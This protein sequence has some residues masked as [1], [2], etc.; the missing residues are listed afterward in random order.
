MG[1]ELLAKDLSL[2][3][4][5]LFP[6]LANAALSVKPVLL[7]VYETY[8]LPLKK[9][10]RPCLTGLIIA[11]L[12]GLEEGSDFYARTFTLLKNICAAQSDS[13]LSA[14]NLV[15]PLLV[16]D[17]KYFY[18]CLWSAIISQSSI[19]FP[20]I[21]FVLT[22]YENKMKITTSVEP[23]G[24]NRTST[25]N[26]GF[27]KDE[28]IEDQLYLIGNSI[29]LMINAICCCLQDMN[30]LVQRSI[31][32]LMCTCLPLSTQQITRTDK[33]NLIVVAIHVILRRDMSLNRRIYA[34]FMGSSSGTSTNSSSSTPGSNPNAVNSAPNASS[35]SSSSSQTSSSSTGVNGGTSTTTTTATTTAGSSSM[36]KKPSGDLNDPSE[37]FATC[38]EENYFNVHTKELLIQAIKALLNSRR[39]PSLV[40]YLF[41]DESS[42]TSLWVNISLFLFSLLL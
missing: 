17:D 32:D 27:K 22:N 31:L 18:T 23:A 25:S 41:T 19:R 14:A 6:L 39:D 13:S 20:A 7:S 34:W 21:Q 33:I 3:S 15:S 38:S 40:Q 10:L 5:G 26:S 30:P 29:D 11:L 35:S 42:S 16:A 4:S 1:P 24:L 8:F 37:G 2:Y 12:P 28:H 9:S 36:K